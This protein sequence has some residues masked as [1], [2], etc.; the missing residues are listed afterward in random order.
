MRLDKNARVLIQRIRLE[1]GLLYAVDLLCKKRKVEEGGFRSCAGRTRAY[2]NG[3]WTPSSIT[4]LT[5][6]LCA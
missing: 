1:T 4:L 2:W 6:D 3:T 5:R